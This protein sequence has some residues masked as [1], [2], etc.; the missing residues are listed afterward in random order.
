MGFTIKSII[1][2]F[3]LFL[4]FQI[5]INFIIEILPDL[6]ASWSSD[7][8]NFLEFLNTN[9]NGELNAE[10]EG[11]TL[12]EN[13]VNSINTENLFNEGIID[14]FLGVLQVIG[15]IIVFIIEVA[16]SI[17]FTPSL[18]Y[19]ILLYDF[20]GN[21]SLLLGSSLIINIGF[22]SWLFYIIFK[23]RITS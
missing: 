3:L 17:L 15:T 1:K 6:T 19:Q 23:R 20:V 18:I 4:A 7:N 21:S 5:S 10:N 2:V 14:S 9:V 12:K 13:L 16:V 11:T 22:Y 8:Q